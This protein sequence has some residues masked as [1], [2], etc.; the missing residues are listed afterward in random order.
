MGGMDGVEMLQE[1][2]GV[3]SHNGLEHSSE[4]GQ[5]THNLLRLPAD[6]VPVWIQLAAHNHVKVLE[7]GA[8]KVPVI[9]FQTRVSLFELVDAD[10]DAFHDGGLDLPHGVRHGDFQLDDLCLFL[11]LQSLCDMHM[12]ARPQRRFAEKQVP[13]HGGER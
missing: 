13:H 2:D 6:A 10:F 8:V 9:H 5:I 7:E 12:E 3:K 1:R 11:P 4:D